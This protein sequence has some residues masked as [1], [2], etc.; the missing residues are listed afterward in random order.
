[1]ADSRRS[2]LRFPEGGKTHSTLTSIQ[3]AAQLP[4]L[5]L[6]LGQRAQQAAE[7]DPALS[8]RNTFPYSPQEIT[9]LALGQ[10]KEVS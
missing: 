10:N 7:T 1:M 4:R 8:H 9:E 6:D 3:S 2:A 5:P